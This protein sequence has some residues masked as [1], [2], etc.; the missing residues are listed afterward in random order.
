MSPS[1]PWTVYISSVFAFYLFV[2]G[3]FLKLLMGRKR[4]RRQG[5][6]RINESKK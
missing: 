6:S 4:S 3:L 5:W 2:F 1:L